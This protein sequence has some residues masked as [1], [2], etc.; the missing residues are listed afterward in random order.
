MS[1]YHVL[2]AHETGKNVRVA[3]HISIPDENNAAGVNKRLALTQ[4]DP[5]TESAYAGTEQAE[6]D[7]LTAGEL[8]EYVDEVEFSA[9]ASNEQKL[10]AVAARYT[11]L[12]TTIPTRLG[13]VLK[14][15]GGD[16]S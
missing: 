15:W 10:E 11:A 12:S 3:F 4:S 2:N 1:N 9:D 7:Q 16:A 6:L 14:F 13:K 8:Y 5:F